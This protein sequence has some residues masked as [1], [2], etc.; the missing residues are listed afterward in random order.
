MSE[1]AGAVV[2]VVGPSGSSR[3]RRFMK[4]GAWFVGIALF[5]LVLQLLGVDVK[6][7][8]SNLWDQIKEVP[9]GYIVAAL[10][11]QSGQTLFAGVSYYGILSA[12][13]PGEVTLAPVVTAYAATIGA[14]FA[15]PGYAALRMP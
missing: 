14:I 1:P 7:W 9:P 4:I 13:Y 11:F 3:P 5:V 6:G 2:D 10:V 8:L 15:S 12:A